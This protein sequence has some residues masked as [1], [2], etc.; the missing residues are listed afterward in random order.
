MK[1]YEVKQKA[2]D[3]QEELNELLKKHETYLY[4]EDEYGREILEITAF[5]RRVYDMTLFNEDG[6]IRELFPL[7][8]G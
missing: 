5:R 2:I 8:K 7:K 3:F 4:A 6:S 1:E